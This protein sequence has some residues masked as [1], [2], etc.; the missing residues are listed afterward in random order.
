[1][2]KTLQAL[3]I[4]W[5]IDFF[6][7]PK[8]ENYLLACITAAGLCLTLII[9][10]LLLHISIFATQKI[11]MRMRIATNCLIYKKV[12][13]NIDSCLKGLLK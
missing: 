5:V 1:M 4:G 13:V 6:A 12:F 8:E 11:G 7:D 3:L 9:A 10:T 2:I